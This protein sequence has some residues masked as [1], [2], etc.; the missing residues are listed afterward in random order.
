[1]VKRLIVSCLIAAVAIFLLAGCESLGGSKKAQEKKAA[2]EAKVAQQAKAAQDKAA[3]DKAA[4]AK[5]AQDKAAADKAA[6]DKA[7]AAKAAQDKA[8]ADKAAADK[9]AAAKA[10]QDKAAADKAAAAKAAQDKAA[11]DKAVLDK[12]AQEAI[13]AAKAAT[14]SKGFVLRVEC[15]ADSPYTDKDGKVWVADQE[16]ATGKDWGATYGSTL[17][18]GNLAMANTQAPRIYETERYSMD[19]YTF[20]VPN[21]KY[22]VVLHFAETFDGISGPGQRVFSVT[23]NK[24]TVIKDIDLYKEVDFSKPLVKTFKDIDVTDGQLVIGF[25]PNIEN[26]EINGIEIIGQ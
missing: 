21:G 15:G 1:M 25:I 12:A 20:K 7:A 9:A 22:T 2:Q 8:A 17:D 18:R 5:A 14:Q 6:A 26:P 3:A 23:I 13:A 19:N 11:A 10:A 4:A 24:N 16:M